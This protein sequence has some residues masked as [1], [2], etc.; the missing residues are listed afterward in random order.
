[1]KKPK[2]APTDSPTGFGMRVFAVVNAPN[3]EQKG[4]HTR[5][6]MKSFSLWLIPSPAPLVVFVVE[7]LA[8]Q[9]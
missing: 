7:Q 4:T 5:R 8:A 1:M 3:S 2:N 9:I 6:A